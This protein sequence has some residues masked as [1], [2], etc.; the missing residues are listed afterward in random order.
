M[1]RKIL[2]QIRE[3]KLVQLKRH[4]LHKEGTL[5]NAFYQ[6]KTIFVHIPKTAG[7]SVVRALYGEV[8]GGGHRKISFFQ[9]MFGKE[10]SKYFTFCFVRNPYDRLYSAYQFLI[11]GG[12]NPHDKNAYEKYLM[13]FSDF[14]DFVLHGLN[15]K[16]CQEVVH[17][18]PQTQFICDKKGK[19]IVDFVGKFENLQIDINTIAAKMNKKVKLQHL[20]SSI[21]KD[22]KEIYTVAMRQK[23]RELYQKDFELLGY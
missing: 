3:R 10:F 17:F 4:L 7:I 20:N 16:L 21:K 23:V 1:L 8:K 6:S 11:K 9:Y 13:T 5:L 12:L 19:I 18:V 15:Q 22:M 14:E 2:D